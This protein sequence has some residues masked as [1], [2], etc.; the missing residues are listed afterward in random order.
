MCF[1]S[2]V[3]TSTH[4]TASW[5][6]NEIWRKFE[7]IVVRFIKPNYLFRIIIEILNKCSKKFS[8]N[9]WKSLKKCWRNFEEFSCKLQ[10]NSRI[11]IRMRVKILKAQIGILTFGYVCTS[12]KLYVKMSPNAAASISLKFLSNIILPFKFPHISNELKS[13]FHHFSWTSAKFSFRFPHISLKLILF[14]IYR[15][16]SLFVLNN[17]QI[18]LTFSL[19]F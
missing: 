18:G 4:K 15:I 11:C 19:F 16:F 7:K 17:Q 2:F 13:N 9:S 10:V 1:L 6:S 14:Q 5:N 3:L 8:K 12:R